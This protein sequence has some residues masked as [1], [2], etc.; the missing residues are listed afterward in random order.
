LEFKRDLPG[1]GDD[2]KREFLADVSALANTSGGDLLYGVEEDN[3]C[4]S[5]ITGIAPDD[6]DAEILR[7][8]N[9][10]NSGLEPR[11][12]HSHLVIQCPTGTVLLFRIEK[13]WNAPHRVIFKGYDKFF[14][15]T[16]TGKYPL[17]VQQLRRAFVENSSVAERIRN[18]RTD[19]LANIIAGSTPV[20][21]ARGSK[22]VI[23]LLPFDAFL[24]K[25]QFDL[26][27]Q[28]P[29]NLF[30]PLT[31]GRL[32]RSID[33]R[34]QN[35]RCRFTRWPLPVLSTP[36]SQRSRRTRGRFNPEPQNDEPS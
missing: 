31:A 34:R 7:L 9:I 11:I 17:D 19:R 28:L 29:I 8:E 5:T 22:L 12:R 14:A 23:H 25:P 32:E 20:P 3:G 6:V 15:R 18:F 13:S 10:L 27:G 36:L 24:S 4:A 2:A 26:R 21:T 30:Q 16:G 33:H 1:G 35:G